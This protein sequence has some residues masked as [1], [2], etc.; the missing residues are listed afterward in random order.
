MTKTVIDATRVIDDYLAIW[1]ETDRT[2]RQA[3]IARTWTED[4]TYTDPAAETAGH[5]GIDGLVAAAQA[6]FPG[7]LFR[8]IGAVDAHHA[9]LRF[10]W[11]AGP[12][13]GEALAAGSDVAVIGDDGRLRRVVGFLDLVPGMA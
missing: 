9:F 8:R 1:N 6:Q 13:G 5:D 11:E 7:F 2:I 3:L 10:C 4:A 12:T